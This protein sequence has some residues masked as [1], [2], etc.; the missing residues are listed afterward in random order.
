MS[1]AKTKKKTGAGPSHDK[2]AAALNESAAAA[3]LAR[4]AA[5][6]A[7]HDELYYRKDAPEISDA[8]YDA[9]RARNDAIEARFP[10]L[11]CDDSPS[12]KVGAAPVGAFGKV[13]QR[14]PML[15]IDNAFSDEKVEGFL[16]SAKAFLGLSSD[17]PLEVTAEPKIDGLSITLHY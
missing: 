15:S 5:E 11:V 4:L 3:E 14:V 6:I 12:L 10:Q 1:K 8:A 17:Q 16:M 7:H 2:S 9:L 13:R